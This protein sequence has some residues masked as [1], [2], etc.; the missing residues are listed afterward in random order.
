M[1]M[2]CVDSDEQCLQSALRM[3]RRMDLQPTA[4]GFLTGK[5]ALA[6]AAEHA[7]DAALLEIDVSDMDGVDLA[8]RLRTLRPETAILFLTRRRDRAIDAWELLPHIQG[9][10]LKPVDQ[11][12][13]EA[14]IHRALSG[15]IPAPGLPR[16]VEVKCFGGFDLFVD[17]RIVVFPRSKAKELLACLVDRR[18]NWVS[19]LV[20]FSTLWENRCYDKPAQKY[21]DNVARCMLDTLEESGIPD[22][23]EKRRGAL[24]IRPEMIHCDFYGFLD[25]DLDLIYAFRG[26]YMNDYSWASV[27]EAFADS[28]K[29]RKIEQ[30]SIE[31]VEDT[32]VTF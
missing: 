9:F 6:W 15:R 32:H 7:V 25:G 30:A 17:G 19:R 28:V 3:C 11:E 29:T 13:L 18:G 5:Q 23:V 20:A 10:L 12:R 24:R 1:R 21:F 27:T 16:R 8:R 31:N 22:I 14:E 2:I 4:E 26:E